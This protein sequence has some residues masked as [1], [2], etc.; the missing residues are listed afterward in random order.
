[1][2]VHAAIGASTAPIVAPKRA[3]VSTKAAMLRIHSI[4]PETRVMNRNARTPSAPPTTPPATPS[5]AV[6]PRI[7]KTRDLFTAS[8]LS[9][10][11]RDWRRLAHIPAPPTEHPRRHQRHEQPD[12]QRLHQ[13]DRR[14][15]D[16]VLVHL[17]E[18]PHL[19]R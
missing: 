15:D 1:M 2:S 18:L 16:R 9:R 19:R 7:R 6:T 5:P 17:G 4:L 13:R 3:A 12:R 14:V 10:G 8:K 11:P